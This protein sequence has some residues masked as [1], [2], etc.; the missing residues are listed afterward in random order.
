MGCDTKGRLL[1]NV[2]EPIKPG[3]MGMVYELAHTSY[4]LYCPPPHPPKEMYNRI[5]CTQINCFYLNN[6]DY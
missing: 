5:L 6:F 1:D 3:S 2:H 4:K